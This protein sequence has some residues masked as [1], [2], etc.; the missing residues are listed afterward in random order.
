MVSRSTA[1]GDSAIMPCAAS[2]PSTFCQ[3]QV[4]TSSLSHGSSIA[5]TAEVA[6]QIARPCAV[7]RD[8]VAIGHAHARGGAVPRED[9]VVRPVDRA[10]DR[11]ARRSRPQDVR[12]QLQFLRDV[13]GPFAAEAFPRQHVDAARAEQR[14]QRHLD[15]AG[16]GGRH[17]AEAIVGGN[18]EHIAAELDDFGE[19]GLAGGRS[20]RSSEHGV[21]RGFRG[22]SRGAWRRVRTKNAAAPAAMRVCSSSRPF[23]NGA[24]RWG[25][26]AHGSPSHDA[27]WIVNWANWMASPVAPNVLLAAR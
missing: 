22:S 3:D 23:Q 18:A 1:R 9:H 4:T 17:D 21:M 24:L 19:L 6:S 7:G 27:R 26:V 5:N 14:P 10:A 8:P 25:S 11:A 20:M 13:A 2:P 15:R 12:R 16:I